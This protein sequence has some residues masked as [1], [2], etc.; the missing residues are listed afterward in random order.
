MTTLRVRSLR[1]AHANWLREK[2]A[3]FRRLGAG[4]VPFAVAQD[5]E[6][7]STRYERLAAALEEGMSSG[8]SDEAADAAD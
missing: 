7:V 4:A 5:L 8:A 1:L 6:R 3:H 2:A